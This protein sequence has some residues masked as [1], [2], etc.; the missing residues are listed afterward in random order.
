MLERSM[1]AVGVHSSTIACGMI[2][3]EGV[4]GWMDAGYVF[5]RAT[6][7]SVFENV[8]GDWRRARHDSLH[9]VQRRV[10]IFA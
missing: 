6:S 4:L 8:V 10:N 9:E 1:P 5:W 7:L 3:D 2:L